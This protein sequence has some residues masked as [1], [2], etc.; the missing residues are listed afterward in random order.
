MPASD[1]RRPNALAWLAALSLLAATGCGGK[2]GLD[3]P[4]ARL[5]GA[6]DAGTDA[7]VPCVEVPP[8]GGVA[9]VPLDTVARLRRADV[10]F[11][12]DVTLSMR[13][14]IDQIRARLRDTLAPAIEGQIPDSQLALATHGRFCRPSSISSVVCMRE[15]GC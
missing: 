8:D 9:E 2:T 14:E 5:D 6:V 7:T 10:V 13:D 15:C 1:A 4:D 3:L 12:V 11:L